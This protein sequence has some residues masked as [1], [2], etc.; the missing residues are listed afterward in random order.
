MTVIYVYLLTI[1]GYTVMKYN[2][3]QFDTRDTEFVR[4]ALVEFSRVHARANFLT[5]SFL[6]KFTFVWIT[7]SDYKS[8][9][10]YTRRHPYKIYIKLPCSVDL[11]ME[12]H[13]MFYILPCAAREL[14]YAYR[15]HTDQ[16]KYMVC[17]LPIVRDFTIRREANLTYV[18]AVT[19]FTRLHNTMQAMDQRLESPFLN[20]IQAVKS[21]N[22]ILHLNKRKA[23]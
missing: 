12:L 16:F 14:L 9:S 18:A 7:D 23:R 17:L 3:R 5:E 6:N 20:D 1:I 10:M 13:Y 8:L 22:R 2:I 21:V 19:Y 15:Y 4:T 11:D